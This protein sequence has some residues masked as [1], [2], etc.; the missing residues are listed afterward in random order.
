MK[1][2]NNIPE[3]EIFTSEIDDTI[4]DLFKPSKKIEIDPLTQEV[5][6]VEID[7]TIDDLF[8]PSKKIEIDPLTQEVKDVEQEQED[9]PVAFE[10]TEEEKK[11]AQAKPET[12][13]DR[14]PEGLAVEEQSETLVELDLELEVE[15]ETAEVVSEAEKVKTPDDM[16]AKLEQLKQQIF[17]IE[18]EITESQIHETLSLIS[19]LM[20][21]P[22][23]N[24]QPQAHSMMA[25]MENVLRNFQYY[26]EN[27]P[28]IAPSI[29]KKTTQY[30]IDL[31]TGKDSSI[32]SD[33]SLLQDLK[34]LVEKPEKSEKKIDHEQIP[35]LDE[36]PEQAGDM[37][38]SAP[39]VE[40]PTEQKQPQVDVLVSME[41]EENPATAPAEPADDFLSEQGR[42][43]LK[44]HLIELKR[45][46]NRIESLEKLLSKT[47]GMDKLYSF[48]HDIRLGLEGQLT[49]LSGFF[50]QNVELYLP[51][52]GP[53]RKESTD[54][55]GTAPAQSP[56]QE[57]F[58]IS[59]D[60]V[61]VGFPADQVVYVSGPP[62]HSKSAI[63]K[64]ATLSLNKLKPWPWSKLKGL[65]RGRLGGLEDSVLSSMQFPVVRQIGGLK[66]PVP[67]NFTVILLFDGKKG[68][69]LLSEKIPI[70]I[71][72]PGDAKWT[73]IRADG[74]EMEV[75]SHGNS[76]KVATACSLNQE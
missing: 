10:L 72:I 36:E 18:W 25:L 56:W 11:A 75:E 52:R 5:K 35:V 26:P 27:I 45:Y 68:V 42:H 51:E 7:D 70:G 47:P 53:A 49:E 58:S 17:T 65:F 61:E 3:P 2:G 43:L 66:L 34:A 76:I 40:Q 28:A 4:D 8:K 48:Q 44:K 15:G 62:W 6:D 54:N 24:G 50:F 37:Q 13:Q 73:E 14:E 46:I 16:K 71:E 69:A 33:N 22:E 39:A 59:I 38:G 20:A 67:P 63:K 12:E 55:S 30:L 23:V 32:D 60:G 29:L 19:G 74:F 9:F 41:K 21:A 57:L 1:K 64:A 31:L